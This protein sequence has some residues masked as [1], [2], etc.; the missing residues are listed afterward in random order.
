MNEN[1]IGKAKKQLKKHEPYREMLE[2]GHIVTEISKVLNISWTKVC[3][4]ILARDK[5]RKPWT[6][7]RAAR[8]DATIIRT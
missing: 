7:K 4:A 3:N 1:G 8:S 2:E 5:I 6:R